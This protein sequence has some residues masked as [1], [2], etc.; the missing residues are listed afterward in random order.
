M[1]PVE[2]MTDDELT[3]ACAELPMS[4]EQLKAEAHQ[5]G[6]QAKHAVPLWWLR[7]SHAGY[8][9][10]QAYRE[11]LE[12]LRTPE[13]HAAGVAAEKT[14]SPWQQVVDSGRH[15]A[16]WRA[17]EQCCRR[18]QASVWAARKE[19]DRRKAAAAQA[20]RRKVET[21]RMQRLRTL[22]GWM[23]LDPTAFEHECARLLKIAGYD[24]VTVTKASGDGGIDVIAEC[25][26]KRFAVQCKKY[27]G[28]IDPTDVRALAGV[29]AI[30]GYTGGIFMTTGAL[31]QA[32][33][34]EAK[35]AGLTMYAGQQLVDLA[36]RS[37]ASV[38]PAESAATRDG[39][40]IDAA[41]ASRD[42]LGENPLIGMLP[43]DPSF[44]SIGESDHGCGT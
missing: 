5:V 15:G 1:K 31:S 11:C 43:D 16:Y 22:G 13:A 39:D 23:G 9:Y 26:G 25:G 10:L 35:L 41:F 12:R 30:G 34:E 7:G 32:T 21:D 24:R 4:P 37:G 40:P 36:L 20:K 44:S 33:R 3:Q 42:P 27:R 8:V 19:R 18:L 6:L 29:V 38:A 2:N 28:V 14:M 17:Y